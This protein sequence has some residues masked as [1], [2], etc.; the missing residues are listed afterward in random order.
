MLRK[1]PSGSLLEQI[2]AMPN[3]TAAWRQ[4]RGN[5]AR[6]RRPHSCGVDEVSV[7]AFEQQ[8]ETNLAELQRSL[9]NGSYRPLP[10]RRVEMGKR[11][12]GKR[13]IGVLAVRD[14]IAQRAA[15]QVLESLFEPHFLD[16]SY[17][18]RPGRSTEDAIHR[19]LCHRQAGCEWVF[20]ADIA[21]CFDSLDHGLLLRFVEEQVR[22]PAVVDLIQ[23]WLEAGMLDVDDVLQDD[24]QPLDRLT[25]RALD[26]VTGGLR[27][28]PVPWGEEEDELASGSWGYEWRW[29]EALKRAGTDLVLFGLT[30]VRPTIR[31][32]RPLARWLARRKKVVLGATGAVGALTLAGLWL[33]LRR[34]EPGGQGALQ[35]G[36]LSPLLANVYLH[37]FDVPMTEQGHRLVRYADDLVVCCETEAEA[38]EA[39]R[40]AAREL[41]DLRLRLNPEKTRVTSF[42]QGFQFLGRRFRGAKVTPPL[43]SRRRS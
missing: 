19:I 28:R 2:G 31:R 35:G 22:E 29:R 3:L 26:L 20:D 8:W 18:F 32:V 30:A 39:A 13:V 36:A 9:L 24:Q 12:G 1:E 27:P 37:Q 10:P 41:A 38:N 33:T 43:E 40:D 7:A 34:M 42:D 15:Q 6:A 5:I 23:S 17:G 11:G 21:T 16:C 25:D 14:R 4:V